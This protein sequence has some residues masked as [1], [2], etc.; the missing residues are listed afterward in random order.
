MLAL[1]L[2]LSAFCIFRPQAKKNVVNRL[3]GDEFPQRVDE[4][5]NALER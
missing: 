1:D 3:G 4:N 2:F 5:R